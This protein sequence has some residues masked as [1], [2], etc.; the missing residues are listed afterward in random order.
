MVQRGPAAGRE[1]ERAGPRGGGSRRG[2]KGGCEKTLAGEIDAE[3]DALVR[4]KTAGGPD[5][6]AFE[7]AVRRRA[8]DTAA[9]SVERRLNADCAD[10][11][12]S[13]RDKLAA[14]GLEL[15]AP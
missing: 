1:R 12:L 13:V 6:E 7:Q 4:S 14:C 9:R 2:K 11:Q 10:H 15:A 5:F 8:L 3:I